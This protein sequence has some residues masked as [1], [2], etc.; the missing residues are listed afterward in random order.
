[1]SY[2]IVEIMY[3]LSVSC[4][5]SSTFLLPPRTALQR[6]KQAINEEE[7]TIE[8]LDDPDNPTYRTFE[9][10]QSII[11]GYQDLSGLSFEKAENERLR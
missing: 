2:I 5:W 6:D 8:P 9:E 11:Q 4:F 1:M 3:L 7:P 10:L